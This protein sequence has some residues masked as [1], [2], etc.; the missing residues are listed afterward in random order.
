[1]TSET[2]SVIFGIDYR[3]AP[4][5]GFPVS[6]NDSYQALDHII[7]NADKYGIDI[8]RIALWGASAGGNLAAS[9]ALRDA[10]EHNPTRIRHV[11]LVVPALCPPSLAPAVLSVS[12]AS[13]PHF[14]SQSNPLVLT[15]AQELWGTSAAACDAETRASYNQHWANILEFM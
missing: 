10:Q 3:L 8:T 15:G 7:A 14:T 1:M 2:Q 11:S 13:Y 5:H 4:E 6:Q 12:S 9:V